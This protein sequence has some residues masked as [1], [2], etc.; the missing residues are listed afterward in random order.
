MTQQRKLKNETCLGFVYGELRS[1][2]NG[3]R[4]FPRTGS[5]RLGSSF[6][7]PLSSV[8]RVRSL[9]T[10]N[11]NR[12]LGVACR[13]TLW[14]GQSRR[15]RSARSWARYEP[16]FSYS[17]WSTFDTSS[18][19]NKE[20]QAIMDDLKSMLTKNDGDVRTGIR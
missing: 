12:L 5:G 7:Q 14:S 6:G 17:S 20:W 15:N 1:Q 19:K 2:S 9:A 4:P 10:R 3:G 13:V 16:V 11:D 18:L 8:I